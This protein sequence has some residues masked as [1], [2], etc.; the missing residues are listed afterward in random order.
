MT[1][2]S[3]C[4]ARAKLIACNG[5]SYIDW[6]RPPSIQVDTKVVDARIAVMITATISA[7]M[8]LARIDMPARYSVTVICKR[9]RG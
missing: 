8:N 5:L 6:A 7:M 1:M 2:K 9:I 3:V 4:A